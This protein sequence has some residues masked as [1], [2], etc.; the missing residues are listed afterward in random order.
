MRH[1]A[2]G[3]M[4]PEIASG[5]KKKTPFILAS[6]FVD[7]G[8]NNVG[9]RVSS[10][11]NIFLTNVKQNLPTQLDHVVLEEDISVKRQTRQGWWLAQKQGLPNENQPYQKDHSDIVLMERFSF[12]IK[13]EQNLT[14]SRPTLFF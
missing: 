8:D 3:M 6:R 13:N 11:T 12:D 2:F 4:V 7:E 1:T 5:I 14:L 9:G 10:N